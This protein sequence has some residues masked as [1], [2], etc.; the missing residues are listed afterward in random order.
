MALA[1]TYEVAAGERVDHLVAPTAP[2]R[3]ERIEGLGH[4]MPL[5]APEEVNRL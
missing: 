2:W 5:E 1:L 3:Y 4:W